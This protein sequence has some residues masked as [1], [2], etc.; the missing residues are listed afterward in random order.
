[1]GQQVARGSRGS[2]FASRPWG[3]AR[4]LPRVHRN[5]T[6]GQAQLQAQLQA[7]NG[8]PRAAW[9]ALLQRARAA[10]CLIL[11][12]G[13]AGCLVARGNTERVLRAVTEISDARSAGAYACAPRQLAL[14]E[15]HLDFAR[16]EF[17]G[18][19]AERGEAHLVESELHASA[20]LRLSRSKQCAGPR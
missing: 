13:L 3:G 11:P 17:A 10:W 5:Q 16:A 19:D 2:R 6:G 12:M 4:S 14:A 18:G 8:R 1:M 7:P 20:A 15:A 9:S